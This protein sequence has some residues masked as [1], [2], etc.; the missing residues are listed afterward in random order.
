MIES[1]T[2]LQISVKAQE[3]LPHGWVWAKIEDVVEVRLQGKFQNISVVIL[4]G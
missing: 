2:K 1:E 4:F 3:K